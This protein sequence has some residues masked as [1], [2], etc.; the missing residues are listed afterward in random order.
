MSWGCPRGPVGVVWRCAVRYGFTA[1]VHHIIHILQA[2]PI[3]IASHSC[4]SCRPG[5]PATLATV[6]HPP[7]Y[8]S[9]PAA[10][11]VLREKRSRQREQAAASGRA[12]T[13]AEL[14]DG[15]FSPGDP[16]SRHGNEKIST[17]HQFPGLDLPVRSN[18]GRFPPPQQI[19]S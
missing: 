2:E 8:L 7:P 15:F 14:Q 10:L 9:F 13:A 12:D 17:A 4:G 1:I 6:H 3:S 18:R 16:S 5:T 11:E 19:K